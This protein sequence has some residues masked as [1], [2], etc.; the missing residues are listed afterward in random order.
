MRVAD[1]ITTILP[2]S[3]VVGML[4]EHEERYEVVR[5]TQSGLWQHD[6]SRGRCAGNGL[7]ICPI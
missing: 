1:R 2:E 3:S 4:L 5:S 7:S 6:G